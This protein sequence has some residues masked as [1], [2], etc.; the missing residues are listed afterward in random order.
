MDNFKFF[1]DKQTNRQT[2][3]AKTIS[4]LMRGYKNPVENTVITSIFCLSP[5]GFCTLSLT[6][7]ITSVV[8]ILSQTSPSFTYLQCKSFE[9]TVG[10]G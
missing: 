1:A 2:D 7:T 8:L 9:N 10:K 4:L 6:V 3:G 5:Q